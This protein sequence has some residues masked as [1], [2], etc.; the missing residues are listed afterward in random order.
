[1]DTFVYQDRL[2]ELCASY[3]ALRFRLRLFLKEYIKK[4]GAV[5]SKKS[6]VETSFYGDGYF[7][8]DVYGV[9][10]DKDGCM[11]VELEDCAYDEGS[12]LFTHDTWLDL[13]CA[14]VGCHEMYKS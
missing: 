11:W 12:D 13:A 1:M 14:I 2:D 8:A 7:K 10:I 6:I 3:G 9:F 5:K 4:F